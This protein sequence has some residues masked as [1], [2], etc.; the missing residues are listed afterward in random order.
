MVIDKVT[1]PCKNTFK[2]KNQGATLPEGFGNH[3]Q[4]IAKLQKARAISVP[5]EVL[6]EPAPFLPSILRTRK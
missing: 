6:G 5:K 1:R 4:H 2:G 3:E